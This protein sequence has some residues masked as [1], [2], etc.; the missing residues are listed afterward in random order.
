M[1]CFCDIPLSQIK[2]HI[3]K[4]GRYGIGLSK[5][6]GRRNGLNPVFYMRGGSALSKSIEA[7][8][9]NLLEAQRTTLSGIPDALKNVVRYMKPYSGYFLRGVKKTKRIKFYDEREWRYIPTE[10]G[11]NVKFAL[12]ESEYRNSEMLEVANSVLKNT[13]LH[14]EP[15]DIKYVI[16]KRKRNIRNGKGTKRNK[17]KKI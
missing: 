7:I 9:G 5:E 4:Y 10:S 17:G 6:W 1:V 2:E 13:S 12:N 3:Y 8:I 11:P 16:V 15:S 14:F